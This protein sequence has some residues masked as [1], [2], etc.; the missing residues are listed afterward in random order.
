MNYTKHEK[1]IKKL[2]NYMQTIKIKLLHKIVGNFQRLRF[3]TCLVD[4]II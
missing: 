2:N 1:K 4:L 3:Q